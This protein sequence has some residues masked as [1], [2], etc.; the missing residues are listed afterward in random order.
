MSS[1]SRAQKCCGRK[2]PSRNTLGLKE[3]AE[4]LR[5]WE[6]RKGGGQQARNLRKQPSSVVQVEDY[7]PSR[8]ANKS[9]RYME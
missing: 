9:R 8:A 7:R 2:P 1:A 5:A 3:F 4:S 6:D